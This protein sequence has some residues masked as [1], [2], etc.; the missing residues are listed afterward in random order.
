MGS[1]LQHN[2]SLSSDIGGF[3]FVRLTFYLEIIVDPEE[4]VKKK[5]NKLWGLCVLS[6]PD[7]FNDNVLHNDSYRTTSK[8][9][10]DVRP[11]LEAQAAFASF[12]CARLCVGAILCSFSAC[13]SV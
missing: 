9:G 13:R 1:S 3:S 4:I 5:K 6:P 12:T 2:L 10:A 11:V 8:S 7:V